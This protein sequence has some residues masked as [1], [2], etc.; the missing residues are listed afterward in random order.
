MEEY[1]VTK[2]TISKLIDKLTWAEHTAG[3]LQAE[4]DRL[5]KEVN[6]LAEEV[7]RLE[8][9]ISD[10]CGAITYWREKA[11]AAGAD[12]SDIRNCGKELDALLAEL[13]ESLEEDDVS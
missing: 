12:L 8:K 13:P 4:N 5:R 6:D 7:A 3:T 11:E 1:S 10:N 9:V 2:Y